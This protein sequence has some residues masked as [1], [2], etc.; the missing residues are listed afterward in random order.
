MS[1]SCT[2]RS[3]SARAD[4]AIHIGR[5]A[6]GRAEHLLPTSHL[7]PNSGRTNPGIVRRFMSELRKL[8]RERRFGRRIGQNA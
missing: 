8:T 6:S 2:F 7:S 4:V 3:A 5:S 1:T